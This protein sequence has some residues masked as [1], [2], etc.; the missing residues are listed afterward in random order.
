MRLELGIKFAVK[1]ENPMKLRGA[2]FL[3]A[4]VFLGPMAARAQNL[5]TIGVTLLWT[6]T[7]NVNGAGIHVAQ[8]EANNGPTT[9]N[10][11]VNSS[12]FGQ[13][14]SLFT[15]YSSNGSATTFPNSLGA[16]S[17]HADAVGT[18]FYGIP[19]GVATNVAHVD[20]YEAGYFYN[21]IIAGSVPLNNNDPVVNQSFNFV[22]TGVSQQQTIDSTYDNY[23]ERYNTLFVSGVGNG[24]SVNAPATCYN[25][26]GVAVDNGSSSTGP[27][28]DN[29]RA[30][31]DITAP[32]YPA[33]LTSFSTPYVSGAAAV[34]RQAG[35]RG[36]GGSSTNAAADIR[37]VKALLL[38]GAVKPADWTNNAPSPLDTRYGAGVLN[39][40]NLRAARRRQ[41][42]LYC[43]HQR[44]HRRG[45]SPHWRQWHGQHLKRLGFQHQ[46]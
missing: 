35:A 26:I 1:N 16:E 20:N 12:S 29:G 43:F 31:P 42:W 32:G 23:T 15:Y 41:A 19:N 25:G 39:V 8:P 38:N 2:Q 11:Q 14:T 33:G 18:N 3:L 4:F 17:S 9:T 27:T 44:F 30:K 40:F 7:T 45:T 5:D 22:V 6:I 28:L 36:D 46:H 10:W 34:L 24:G 37:T 21:S 13:L